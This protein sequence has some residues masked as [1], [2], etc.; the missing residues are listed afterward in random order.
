VPTWNNWTTP[1]SFFLTTFLLG[2]LAVGTGFIA[3]YS[4]LPEGQA[5]VLAT[6]YHTPQFTLSLI[7]LVSLLLL[8]LEL[9]VIPVW[10]AQLA[11]GP[12]AARQAF[13]RLIH[14]HRV[15]FGLR[16][17][18]MFAGAVLLTGLLS[19]WGNRQNLLEPGIRIVFSLVVV[20]EIV[21]RA[22]FYESQARL[23]V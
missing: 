8:E 1:V 16:L 21:G 22:L 10:V 23:G 18:C 2:A 6:R 4:R 14:K 11:A 13:D 12:E 20:A 3:V 5:A 17:G 19:P 7:S 15:A 9:I